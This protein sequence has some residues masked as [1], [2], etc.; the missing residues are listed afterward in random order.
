M[1]GDE[2]S[3]D[4]REF[5]EEEEVCYDSPFDDL[6]YATLFMEQL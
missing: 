6:G 2:L 1:N 3:W 4:E 5:I